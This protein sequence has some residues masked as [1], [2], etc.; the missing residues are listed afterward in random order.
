[1]SRTAPPPTNLPPGLGSFPLAVADGVT[2]E[3]RQWG[4]G[5]RLLP[6]WQSE[7]AWI[8]FDSHTGYPFLVK[9]G[10]GAIN[11]VTGERYAPEPDYTAEDYFEVPTQPWLDGFRTDAQ[12]I[13]Q[14]VAAPLGRG[15]TVSEQLTGGDDG[16]LRLSVT[17][18]RGEIWAQRLANRA[19][20]GERDFGGP[21]GGVLY[22]A[23]APASMTTGTS[24]SAKNAALGMGAGGRIEQSIATPLEPRENWD[25]DARRTVTLW[26]V[27]SAAWSSLTGRPPTHPPLTIAEY[28]QYGFPWFD[29]YDDSLA[30]Q[31]GSPLSDI[32]SVQE[33]GQR[34]GEDPL[35]DNDDFDP[36]TP[37][38]VG[39]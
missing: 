27:N 22:G 29:W 5:D 32:E 31:G 3:R 15:Y 19:A 6:M 1:M 30:R 13:R 2:P 21:P 38:V 34:L 12:T 35:P 14:F 33:V 9:L 24:R 10:V 25:D 23:P 39:P 4:P 36:P 7:A 18:L 17:P 28:R 16:A 26:I 8:G 37:H 20:A 11:G